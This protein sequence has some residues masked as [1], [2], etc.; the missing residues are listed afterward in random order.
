[1]RLL[2]EPVGWQQVLDLSLKAVFLQ[3]IGSLSLFLGGLCGVRE[4]LSCKMSGGKFRSALGSATA[5]QYDLGHL[6]YLGAWI[7][8][9]FPCC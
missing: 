2:C 6:T 3:G 7:A 5:S 8:S 9:I 4:K 1:M